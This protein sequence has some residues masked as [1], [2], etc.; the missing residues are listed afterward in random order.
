[1][2]QN[3]AKTEAARLAVSLGCNTLEQRGF[4]SHFLRIRRGYETLNCLDIRRGRVGRRAVVRA[5]L[6]ESV[7]HAEQ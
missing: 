4:Y 7:E 5:C 1:M 3:I 2:S 6:K